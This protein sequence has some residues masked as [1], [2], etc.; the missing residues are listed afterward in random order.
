MKKKVVVILAAVLLISGITALGFTIAENMQRA[1]LE[2]ESESLLTL[3]EQ[4][5]QAQRAES[6]GQVLE[7][8]ICGDES[9]TDLRQLMREKGYYEDDITMT[10][11][12]IVDASVYYDMTQEEYDY[13]V[14]LTKLGYNPERLVEIYQFLQL[15]PDNISLM[16]QIYD[17]GSAYMDSQFWIENTYEAIKGIGEQTPSIQEIDAYVKSGIS[18]DEI[19]LC[20]QMSLKGTKPIRQI[21][22]ERKNGTAWPQICESVYGEE[23]LEASEFPADIDLRSL[24]TYI[25]L[26]DKTGNKAKDVIELDSTGAI[27]INQNILT[28]YDDR[29][30]R[31]EVLKQNLDADPQN[32]GKLT[33]IIKDKAEGV[34]DETAQILVEKGFRAKEV[35]EAVET[36]KTNANLEEIRVILEAEDEE[37]AQQ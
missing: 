29:T 28:Q 2:A 18:T 7:A 14:S 21:L 11:A 35:E 16:K 10:V 34:S 13:I 20:Y 12:K 1:A 27:N 26:A 23:E 30:Q 33:Q 22:D 19:L 4:S 5:A 24:Q 8:R 15:T 36:T 25:Q 32:K 17:K 9:G 37:V 3:A 6:S 31:A